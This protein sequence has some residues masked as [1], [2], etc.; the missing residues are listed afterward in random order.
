VMFLTLGMML[1]GAVVVWKD[2]K[3]STS[4]WRGGGRNTHGH[5]GEAV[6]R[7]LVIDL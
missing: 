5:P 4:S 3:H 7:I 6:V 2:V 1:S